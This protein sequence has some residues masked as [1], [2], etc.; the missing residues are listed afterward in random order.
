MTTFCDANDAMSK[1]ID[2]NSYI[3][4]II[5]NV[6]T[7]QKKTYL[8]GYIFYLYFIPRPKEK[9]YFFIPKPKEKEEKERRKKNKIRE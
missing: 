5:G 6:I 4:Y 9:E 8:R 7:R 3:S 1:N 2:L